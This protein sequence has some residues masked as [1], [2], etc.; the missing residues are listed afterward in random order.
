MIALNVF[1]VAFC[2]GCAVYQLDK[3]FIG[4]SLICLGSSIVNAVIVYGHFVK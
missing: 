2:F 4:E 1:A 3:G